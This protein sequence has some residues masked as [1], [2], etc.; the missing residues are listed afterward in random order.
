MARTEVTVAQLSRAGV[1]GDGV[2]GTV[3]GLKFRNDG[4]TWLEIT[5]GAV[6]SRVVTILTGQKVL[7][8]DVDDLQVTIPASSTRMVGLFP[9][10]TFNQAIEAGI[11]YIDLP[12]GDEDDLT[13][14]AYRT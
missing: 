8:L 3:D 11:A 4:R 14:R 2:A 9:P 1:R 7:Q 13:V 12:A 6:A 5:N 10:D